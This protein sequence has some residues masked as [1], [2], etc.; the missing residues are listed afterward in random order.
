MHPIPVL[1][2][3]ILLYSYMNPTP[4]VLPL[5]LVKF[6]DRVTL[7]LIM[8]WEHCRLST[9]KYYVVKRFLVILSI[10][11]LSVISNMTKHVIILLHKRIIGL[12]FFHH[13]MTLSLPLVMFSGSHHYIFLYK[14]VFLYC[15]LTRVKFVVTKKY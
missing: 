7:T 5:S 3:T 6:T 2:E 11:K 13:W 8:I 15:L 9:L 4:A 10:A 1:R 12:W 14:Y